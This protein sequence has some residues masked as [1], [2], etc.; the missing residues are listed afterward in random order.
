MEPYYFE[1]KMVEFRTK[2]KKRNRNHPI[3]ISRVG[4]R[5][6]DGINRKENR[7]STSSKVIISFAMYLLQGASVPQRNLQLENVLSTTHTFSIQINYLG[8][9]LK[10]SDR[11]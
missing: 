8:V 7:Q 3:Q 5:K 6:I 11:R 10:T 9:Y 1:D 4:P 2:V